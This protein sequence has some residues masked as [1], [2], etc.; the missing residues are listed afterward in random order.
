M[1]T[2]EWTRTGTAANPSQSDHLILSK[3]IPGVYQIS[4][5]TALDKNLCK[6]RAHARELP[7]LIIYRTN[8][9]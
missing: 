8:V 3:Q 9:L 7:E 1:E 5:K 2:Y 4:R 6:I